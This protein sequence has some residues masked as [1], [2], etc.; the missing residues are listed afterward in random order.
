MRTRHCRT[1]GAVCAVIA[2]VAGIALCAGQAAA[3]DMD[4]LA[5]AYPSLPWPQCRLPDHPLEPAISGILSGAM[6]PQPAWKLPMLVNGLQKPPIACAITAYSS[7][8][9][10]VGLYTRWGS[11]VRWG[12]CAADPQYWGPGSVIWIGPPVNTVLIVEDTGSAIKGPH[13]FDV[14]CEGRPEVAARIGRSQSSYVPLH[15]TAPR[16]TWGKKPAGW[17]PP[18]WTTAQGQ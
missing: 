3:E 6:G 7:H 16:A 18:I 15:R 10:G 11:K 8:E 4:R 5:A 9:G 12:L 1:I 17:H 14:C 13:R 2:V